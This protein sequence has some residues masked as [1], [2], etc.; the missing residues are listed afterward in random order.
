M[1]KII[2][3]AVFALCAAAGA[4]LYKTKISGGKENGKVQAG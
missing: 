1:K 4:V 2:A 3:A